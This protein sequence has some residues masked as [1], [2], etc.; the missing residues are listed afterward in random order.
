[1]AGE[2]LLDTGALVSLLDRSQSQHRGFVEFFEQ[3]VPMLIRALYSIVGALV[4]LGMYDWTLIPFCLALVVPAVLLNTAYGRK[5][6]E[7]SVSLHDQFEQEVEVIRESEPEKVR[8]HY[9][10]LARWR[11][12][13]SDAEAINF[14]LMELF[15]LGVMVATLVHFCKNSSPQ[16]GDIFAVFRYV[17]MF[18][19]GMDS[20]PKLVQQFSR[21]RDIGFRLA[22]N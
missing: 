7:L 20:A 12:K 22:R 4:F 13:L 11:I 14:S 8:D 21:L 16:P 5:S 18:I 3:C 9:N 17:L 6:Y 10:E 2:L 1:M 15:V 19:M